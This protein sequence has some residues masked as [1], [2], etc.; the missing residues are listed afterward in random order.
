M[1]GKLVQ[2]WLATAPNPLGEIGGHDQWRKRKT[3]EKLS[4]CCSVSCNSEYS[5][6]P[7]SEKGEWCYLPGKLEKR[8]N[9]A[10]HSVKVRHTA[11]FLHVRV[12]QRKSGTTKCYLLNQYPVTITFSSLKERKKQDEE[13]F[14]VSKVPLNSRCTSQSWRRSMMSVGLCL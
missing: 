13:Y 11:D 2:K 4:I 5:E 10:F 6:E 14:E 12:Y 9:N 8:I 1:F 7:A 3:S